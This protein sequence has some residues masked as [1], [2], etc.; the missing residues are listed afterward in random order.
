MGVGGYALGALYVIAK[1]LRNGYELGFEWPNL[2]P[3]AHLLVLVSLAMVAVDVLVEGLL[4][5][6]RRTMDD[7]E[8]EP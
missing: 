6:W 4:G 7:T 3:A 5:G 1:Q 8:E 2:F